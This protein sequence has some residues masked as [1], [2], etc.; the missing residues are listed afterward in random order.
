MK[1]NKILI[2]DDMYL[3]RYL[4]NIMV[5]D[6][7]DYV[8][9]F[10]ETG[11]QAIDLLKNE[12]NIGLVFMDISMPELCGDEATKI[13]KN[14][15]KLNVPIIAATAYDKST[16]DWEIFDDVINKPYSSK[17]IKEILLKYLSDEK[18][19]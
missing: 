4:L 11:K 2:V 6:C 5:R 3:N 8:T 9:C 16:Y 15:L 13:I 17:L 19:N 14:D 7:G 10:A 12:K 18:H 1:E